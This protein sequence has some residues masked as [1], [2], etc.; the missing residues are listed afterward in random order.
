MAIK[1]IKIDLWVLITNLDCV[2]PNGY[3]YC[4]SI[5]I[6]ILFPKRQVIS[7]VK[8]AA[9]GE[10]DTRLLARLKSFL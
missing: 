9:Y 1:V 5:C 7:D 8:I 10:F 3:F 4:L 6:E 2:E